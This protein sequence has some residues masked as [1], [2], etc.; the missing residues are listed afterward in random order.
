MYSFKTTRRATQETLAVPSR[1]WP[2]AVRCLVTWGVLTLA[3]L[4]GSNGLSDS[5]RA[6]DPD[7]SDAV[8]APIELPPPAGMRRLTRDYPIWLDAERKLL[9]VDGEVCLREGQLEMFA[10]PRQ[11]KEHESVV[12]VDAK[13]RYIHAGLL[14]VGAKS[15]KPVQF[16]PDY[17]PATGDV[18]EIF[19]LWQDKE[20]K[21]HRARA[22]DWVR[23][24]R[25]KKPL[26]YDWVFAGSGFWQDPDTGERF[27]HADAGDLICVSNFPSATLDVPVESS[28]ANS[29]LLFEAF[30]ERIPP[31]GTKVR[32]VLK[33]RKAGDSKDD[34]RAGEPD[35]T[36]DA[37]TE[38]D[39]NPATTDAPAGEVPPTSEPED[40]SAE[41]H[42]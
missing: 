34:D 39:T 33:P 8:D 13:S 23:N 1:R 16:D 24:V 42:D 20:G 28:Q 2:F 27:Y 21:R 38:P 5:L 7:A 37:S 25:T 6:Q 32:L 19:V 41:S 22:Q 15:G 18:I 12:V 10:C 29:D 35:A 17:Q 40:V 4:A 30:T 36:P 31:R 11:T 9:V 26:A 14:A 3:G